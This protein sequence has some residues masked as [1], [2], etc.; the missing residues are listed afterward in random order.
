MDD[1][2]KT[3]YDKKIEEMI[4]RIQNHQLIYN[5]LHYISTDHIFIEYI[6]QLSMKAILRTNNRINYLDDKYYILISLALI[7][8][9]EYNGNFWAHIH[10]TYKEMY[11]NYYYLTNARVY[12]IIIKILKQYVSTEDIESGR[13]INS[14]LYHCIVPEKYLNEFYNILLEVY[15]GTFNT[16]LPDKESVHEFLSAIYRGVFSDDSDNEVIESSVT[17]Q[18]YK[19]ISSTRYVMADRRY[20]NEVINFSI[21]IL[22]SIDFVMGNDAKEECDKN[23][24]YYERAKKWFL[25]YGEKRFSKLVANRSSKKKSTFRAKPEFM[26]YE[27]NQLY[28]CTKTIILPE[29]I[30]LTTVKVKIYCDDDLVYVNDA[31]EIDNEI[32]GYV[33]PSVEILVDWNPLDMRFEVELNKLHNY[34]FKNTYMIFDEQGKHLINNFKNKEELFIL[35][36]KNSHIE[37]AEYMLNINQCAKLSEIHGDANY[38]IVDDEVI[39][40]IEFE[41][42]KIIAESPDNISAYLNNSQIELY[43]GNVRVFIPNSKQIVNLMFSHNGKVR[44]VVTNKKRDNTLSIEPDIGLNILDIEIKYSN[45]NVERKSIKFVYDDS[46]SFDYNSNK[47]NDNLIIKTNLKS[48]NEFGV[49]SI[50]AK[51]DNV[52]TEHYVS[53]NVPFVLKFTLPIAFYKNSMGE[54]I[55]F[56]S[57]L[58]RGNFRMYEEI[59]ITGIEAQTLKIYHINDNVVSNTI[60][61]IRQECGVTF[62]FDIGA[63]LILM[64]DSSNYLLEFHDNNEVVKTV[65][66][67]N[68]M[69]IDPTDVQINYIE[70]TNSLSLKVERYLGEDD[71]KVIL[72]KSDQLEKELYYKKQRKE[73]IIG[74]LETLRNYK[75]KIIDEK[76]GNVLYEIEPYI[77]TL[78]DIVGLKF[79][80]DSLYVDYT[81]DITRL[82][83]IRRTHLEIIERL[84][85]KKFSGKIFYETMFSPAV[86]FKKIPFIHVYFNEEIISKVDIEVDLY[87]EEED[88][89]DF[90]IRSKQI[91]DGSDF[92]NNLKSIFKAVIRM[93]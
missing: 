25:D 56:G 30:D 78:D 9:E 89:I 69:E 43:N 38:V 35:T 93:E 42:I 59:E 29:D 52:F 3:I 4:K 57:E 23:E 72:Y 71:L 63:S 81:Y 70:D 13:Y 47:L 83:K 45:D 50:D 51:L 86:Y 8:Y 62:K 77:G 18:K 85:Q 73:M 67:I 76:K 55:P 33:M 68:N 84:E 27:F 22:N 39:H 80:I 49:Y 34:D 90:D 37:N 21:K 10:D 5:E 16:N 44:N 46:L 40:L 32:L 79:K 60:Y 91:Y 61:G 14:L 65:K 17:N 64:D 41:E 58:W 82:H 54:K 28:F 1:V 2:R 75:I 92:N 53:H 36:S 48:R 19:L 24:Y 26:L 88:G 20:R 11:D 6:H 12:S 31:P 15:V 7:G 66:F 74:G 87:D